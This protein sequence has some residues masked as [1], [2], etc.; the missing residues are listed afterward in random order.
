VIPQTE[1][2]DILKAV[3][4]SA[5]TDTSRG[6]LCSVL[7]EFLE[8]GTRIVSTDGHRVTVA[9]L[10]TSAPAGTNSFLAPISDIKEL[11]GVFK[12]KPDKRVSFAVQGDVLMVTNGKATLTVERP[13][14]LT[15]PDYRRVLPDDDKGTAGVTRFDSKFLAQAIKACGGLIGAA[16][17]IDV[18][19]WAQTGEVVPPPSMF[20]PV[21]DLSLEVLQSL[22]IYIM[23]MKRYDAR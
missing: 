7:F 13:A 12:R 19:T 3:A 2:H 10:S 6:A 17:A 23:P 20:R 4:H 14:D 5:S 9:T 11:L 15:F 16:S 1:F 18:I 22:D 21:L 8:D